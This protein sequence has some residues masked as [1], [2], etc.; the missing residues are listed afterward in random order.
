MELK[1]YFLHRMVFLYVRDKVLFPCGTQGF[2]CKVDRQVYAVYVG[3]VR[4]T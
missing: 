4:D 3:A 2:F 1:E